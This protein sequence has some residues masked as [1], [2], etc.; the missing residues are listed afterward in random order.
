MADNIAITAGSGTTVATQDEG[1][2]HYQEVKLVA[3]G[4]GTTEALTKAEDSAHSSGHHGVMAL[5]VRN[6]T[7]TDLSAG[8]TDGDY[9]PLQVDA[10]GKL[11]VNVGTTISTITPG[12]AASALGKAEDAGH[13]TGDVGVMLLGVRNDAAAALSGTDLDYT[14]IGTTSAG[15]VTIHDGG[16]TITVDGTVNAA[17]SGSWTVTANPPS[18]DPATYHVFRATDG[19]NYVTPGTEYTED[20][21][22]AANAGKG[23]LAIGRRD[24]AL[25][26]LTPAE[27]DAVGLRVDTRGALWVAPVGTVAHDAADTDNPVKIG[28]RADTTFQTAVADGDR[29]DALF[30]VYGHLRTRQDHANNWS[31]HEN[32]SS[33]LTDTSVAGAPGAGLSNYVTDIIIS[34][35][36]ATALNVFFEEGASTVL[37]PFYLEAV[38]GR[39]VVIRFS[40]P[41]K[42]TANTALTVTTS[43]AHAH[44]IEVLGFIA[45]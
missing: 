41:K 16:N 32:S 11:H 9:E 42:I 37:G 17:Q 40:T 23:I 27:D 26:T 29:V 19:T 18:P 34:N 36:A 28:G 43:D 1:G 30:D 21:A 35:G 38:N 8:A 13:S 45:P 4:T 14:P 7:A 33:A 12:T 44:S 31:Y 5:A 3:S 6:A 20:G 24:N 25:S 2:V 10:N 22:I 15:A 39:G